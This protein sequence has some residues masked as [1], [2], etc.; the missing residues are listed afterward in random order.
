MKAKGGSTGSQQR[1][2]GGFKR[3]KGEG[4]SG[5]VC[6]CMCVGGGDHGVKKFPLSPPPSSSSGPQVC[7]CSYCDSEL[8]QDRRP[9]TNRV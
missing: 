2:T 6:V 5:C 9:Q 3:V 1:K 4:C 8:Q 7:P